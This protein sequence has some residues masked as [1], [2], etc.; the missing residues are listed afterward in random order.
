MYTDNKRIDMVLFFPL[1]GSKAR[2]WLVCYSFYESITKL[3]GEEGLSESKVMP[4]SRQIAAKRSNI[5]T[6]VC[7]REG[8]LNSSG[9]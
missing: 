3:T 9:M 4:A 5:T 6:K 2:E 8:F 1:P 7:S